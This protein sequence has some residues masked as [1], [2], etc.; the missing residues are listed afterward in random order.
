MKIRRQ[1]GFTLSVPTVSFVFNSFS[2]PPLPAIFTSL[3]MF[4]KRTM[5]NI[6]YTSTLERYHSLSVSCSRTHTNKQCANMRMPCAS[7]YTLSETR[8][9][10]IY[11]PF[12]CLMQIISKQMRQTVPSVKVAQ[13]LLCV[14]WTQLVNIWS[15]DLTALTNFRLFCVWCVSSANAWDEKLKRKKIIPEIATAMNEKQKL[16]E[17][18][19]QR[20]GDERTRKLTRLKFPP[21]NS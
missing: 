21:S 4:N 18:E 5:K 11:F 1:N 19:W 12:V 8:T 10:I 6:C 3:S 16:N 13:C 20:M 17:M 14:G 7:S 2:L 15:H 9:K